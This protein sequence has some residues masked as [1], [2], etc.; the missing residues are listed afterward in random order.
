VGCPAQNNRG[1]GYAIFRESYML[2]RRVLLSV[3]ASIGIALGGVAIAKNQ[4]HA[5]AHNLLGAK[6]NQ[7]GKHEIGKCTASLSDP[8]CALWQS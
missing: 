7:N 5:N 4:H 1:D 6:L 3:V 8:V 2:N